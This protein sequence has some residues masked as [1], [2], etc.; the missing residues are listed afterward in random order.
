MCAFCVP[1]PSSSRRALLEGLY[2]RV[3][4]LPCPLALV[5]GDFLPLN[6]DFLCTD[7]GLGAGAIM[8]K[9]AV[10]T[11]ETPSPVRGRQGG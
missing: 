6:L 5:V 11:P 8:L 9:G 1:L 10:C 4:P 7:C 2:P 3:A